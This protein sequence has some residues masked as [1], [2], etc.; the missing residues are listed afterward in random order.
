MLPGAYTGT[1]TLDD[2]LREADENKAKLLKSCTKS[3]TFLSKVSRP[4]TEGV[5]WS[6]TVAIII[7]AMAAGV[8]YS[9]TEKEYRAFRDNERLYLDRRRRGDATHVDTIEQNKRVEKHRKNAWY[10]LMITSVLLVF[11]VACDTIQV[12][13]ILTLQHCHHEV[14]VGLYWP[15]WTVLGLG[16]PSLWLGSSST[17]PMACRTRS[18]LH[19][20]QPWVLRYSLF[21]PLGTFFISGFHTN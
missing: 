7:L 6:M 13:A 10:C 12:F 1:T 19:T 8:V 3:A 2:L 16:Q 17:R 15:L 11:A 5:Y 14:L 20:E 4:A 18:F 21:V 9:N